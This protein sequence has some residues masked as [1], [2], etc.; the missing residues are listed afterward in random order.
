M[1]TD[2]LLQK[3]GPG[4][5][6]SSKHCILRRFI[7]VHYYRKRWIPNALWPLVAHLRSYFFKENPKY[8]QLHRHPPTHY[9]HLSVR[10]ENWYLIGNPQNILYIE[11]GLYFFLCPY[12]LHRTGNDCKMDS[13][14]QYPKLGYF[15]LAELNVLISA[16]PCLQMFIGKYTS[17]NLK[18]EASF[19]TTISKT[20]IKKVPRWIRDNL[21]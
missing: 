12:W 1:K 3:N 8:L 4:Y 9:R 20:K 5:N 21:V 6:R 17:T 10:K 16:D 11:P 13:Q 7:L 2:I 15:F 14:K 19:M 18:I